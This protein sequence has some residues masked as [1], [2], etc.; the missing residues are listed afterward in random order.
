VFQAKV[1][2]VSV[3]FLQHGTL[4][5]LK[6]RSSKDCTIKILVLLGAIL[7]P[8]RAGHQLSQGM[9]SARLFFADNEFESSDPIANQFRLTRL[10]YEIQHKDQVDVCEG[11]SGD[12]PMPQVRRR[13]RPI[14]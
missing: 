3:T 5:L 1:I 4:T 6:L 10:K 11:G 2:L 8:V 9:A 13:R 7:R 12:A 14:R